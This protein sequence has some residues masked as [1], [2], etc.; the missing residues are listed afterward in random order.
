MKLPYYYNLYYC[1]WLIGLRWEPPFLHPQIRLCQSVTAFV[2]DVSPQGTELFGKVQ[3][4]KVLVVGAGG[5][6]EYTTVPHFRN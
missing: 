1:I 6:G 5:I 2:V 3:K 4:A